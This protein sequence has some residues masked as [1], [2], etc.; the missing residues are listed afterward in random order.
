MKQF[1]F[2][3]G[4]ALLFTLMSFMGNSTS[5]MAKVSGTYG[6]CDYEKLLP[7]T[8]QLALNKD[9]SFHFVDRTNA[10]KPIDVTG[11]WE[12]K[13]KTI[14]LKNYTSARPIHNKWKLDGNTGCIKSRKGMT[15]YRICNV[16]VCK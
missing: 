2:I 16:N 15:Y 10:A 4:S 8:L 5:D 14:T 7:I 12:L 3:I 6:V 1:T 13:D 11:T 9:S